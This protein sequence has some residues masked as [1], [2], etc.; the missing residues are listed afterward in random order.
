MKKFFK[1]F[2]ILYFFITMRISF[3]SYMRSILYFFATAGLIWAVATYFGQH[4]GIH[5]SGENT[6]VSA[7]IFSVILSIVNLIIGTILRILTFPI[8]LLTFGLFSGVVS[9]IL[10][11]MTDSFYDNIA[12]S[13]FLG[14]IVVAMIPLISKNL[15]KK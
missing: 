10:I 4:L 12:I 2:G 3:F 6:F 11:W 7:L 13:H 8:T 1:K 14:Y 5:I 9:V 15:L